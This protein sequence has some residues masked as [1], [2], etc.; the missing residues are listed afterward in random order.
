MPCYETSVV[1]RIRN[2]D[3]IDEAYGGVDTTYWRICAAGK[4]ICLE[5]I[6]ER[7]LSHVVVMKRQGSHLR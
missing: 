3:V 2:T 6:G 1:M 4:Y 5:S 7:K